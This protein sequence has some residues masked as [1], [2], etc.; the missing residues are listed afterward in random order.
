MMHEHKGQDRTILAG[1]RRRLLLELLHK[2]CHRKRRAA[3]QQHALL[4]GI[5]KGMLAIK[6]GLTRA[7]L[8]LST[9]ECNGHGNE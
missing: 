6:R 7:Q 1:V 8:P 9:R 5:C 3:M 2:R 4:L